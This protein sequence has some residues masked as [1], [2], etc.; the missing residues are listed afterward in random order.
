[1]GSSSSPRT[2]NFSHKMTGSRL[3]RPFSGVTA[4][5]HFEVDA[6]AEPVP[7]IPAELRQEN[8]S[9]P[10]S[11]GD[12]SK[13]ETEVTA[14]SDNDVQTHETSV[15][16]SVAKPPKA[17][18][19]EDNLPRMSQVAMSY[20]TNEWAKHLSTAEEPTLESENNQHTRTDS[21]ES[22]KPAPVDIVALQETATTPEPQIVR[23]PV[24]APTRSASAQ[25]KILLRSD[26]SISTTSSS[27]SVKSRRPDSGIK[28]KQFV[29]N[30]K[31]LASMPEFPPQ[32][33]LS[34]SEAVSSLYKSSSHWSSHQPKYQPT[35][36]NPMLA[37][38]QRLASWRASL[39]QDQQSASSSKTSLEMSRNAL[40][41]ERLARVHKRETAAKMKSLK[42]QEFDEKMRRGEMMEK[43]RDALRKMQA[44]A[45]K[46]AE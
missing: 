43:H 42:E 6:D 4:A 35:I 7:E 5:S 26:Q 1:M 41:Q 38:E 16:E 14:P 17:V 3:S 34:S 19:N 31:A 8:K 39:A 33:T 27:Q 2:P 24:P 40:L 10:V 45:S 25:S 13:V 21:Q 23:K 11:N 28:G 9:L 32:A 46:T 20:R 29:K 15:D 37:R 12:D 22:E 36:P 18:L 44:R 30:G